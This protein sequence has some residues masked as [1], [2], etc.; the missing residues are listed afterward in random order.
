MGVAPPNGAVYS[1]YHGPYLSAV[2]RVSPGEAW[3]LF[4]TLL[5]GLIF[6]VLGGMMPLR[7]DL[8]VERR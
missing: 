1:V 2:V 4:F 6:A 5:L 8:V 7:D 3:A